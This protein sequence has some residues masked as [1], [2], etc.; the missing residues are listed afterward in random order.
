AENLEKAAWNPAQAVLGP[1][2]KPIAATGGVVG[3]KGSLAPEGAIVKVAGMPEAALIFRGPA[4]CFDNEEACFEAVT[5]RRYA[6]GCVFVIRYEGT[7]GGP[8]IGEMLPT[9]PFL[10]GQGMGSKVALVTDGRFSGATRGFC[11]GHV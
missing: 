8:G 6:E 10:Y 2:D 4:L 3:L 7:R 5:E 1:A 11:V 9:T